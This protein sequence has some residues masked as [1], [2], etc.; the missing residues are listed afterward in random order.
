MLFGDPATHVGISSSAD[1]E[2]S[3]LSPNGGE[4]TTSGSTYTI[5]WEATSDMATFTLKY[6]MNKGR[7]WKKIAKKVEGTRYDWKAPVVKKSKEKCLVQVIGFNQSGK[8][9]DKDISDS[10]FTIEASE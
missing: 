10:T 6:S 3:V 7:S 8:W 5:Q 1:T 9:V 2:L 4:T